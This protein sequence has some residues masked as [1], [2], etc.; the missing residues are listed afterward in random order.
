MTS[1]GDFKWKAIES[2][3]KASKDKGRLGEEGYQLVAFAIFS[4][5]LFPSEAV[6]I[7]SMEAASAFVEYE[8]GKNNPTS[9]ILAETFLSLNYCRMHGKGTMRCCIPLLFMWIVSHLETPRQVFNN[10]WWFNMRPI[11]WF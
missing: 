4:L 5:V 11:V 3:L 7:I 10:F 9:T 1:F 8:Q 2:R 6:G